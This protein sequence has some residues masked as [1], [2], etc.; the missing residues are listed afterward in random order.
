V[1][2]D[3]RRVDGG[4]VMIRSRMPQTPDVFPDR[5][6]V[7]ETT[8]GGSTRRYLQILTAAGFSSLGTSGD[9]VFADPTH[10]W[11][12][13]PGAGVWRTTDGTARK[14]LGP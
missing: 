6:G 12:D 5:G 7:Y 11:V 10:G 14:Q 2:F 13:E 9:I 8:D 3:A 4:S 1:P